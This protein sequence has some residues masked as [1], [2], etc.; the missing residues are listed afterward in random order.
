MGT[1]CPIL[2]HRKAC[3]CMLINLI[4]VTA[5]LCSLYYFLKLSHSAY[6]TVLSILARFFYSA[7]QIGKGSH[8]YEPWINTMGGVYLVEWSQWTPSSYTLLSIECLLNR[9]SYEPGQFLY[10]SF[11]CANTSP[12]LKLVWVDFRM[13]S[14]RSATRWQLFKHHSH[15]FDAVST[16]NKHNHGCYYVRFDQSQWRF[17]SV[18]LH[19]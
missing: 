14:D 8:L 16:Q 18:L 17:K 9:S 10:T 15:T 3:Y 13:G 1:I 5:L 6:Q 19:Q 4:I 7:K 12:Y 11:C 2:Y